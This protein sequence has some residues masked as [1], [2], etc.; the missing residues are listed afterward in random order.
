M[1][2]LYGGDGQGRDTDEGGT[3]HLP[4]NDVDEMDENGDVQVIPFKKT[5]DIDR[6]ADMGSN[7]NYEQVR[8]FKG[9][10]DKF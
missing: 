6:V 8:K 4:L 1:T 9:D 3:E 10:I 7:L 5:E 2:N